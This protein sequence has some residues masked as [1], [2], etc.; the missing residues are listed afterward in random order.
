MAKH[1]II[2]YGE[3]VLFDGEP[4]RISW[5]ETP[6]GFQ[7]TAGEGKTSN[8]LEQLAALAA[9]AQQRRNGG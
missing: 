6:A 7:L 5:S 4:E 8:T 3:I 2:T 1:L 9:A